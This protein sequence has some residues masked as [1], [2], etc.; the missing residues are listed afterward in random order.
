MPESPHIIQ[1]NID[2]YR[3]ILGRPLVDEQRASIERLLAEAIQHLAL[4]MEPYVR[5]EIAGDEEAPGRRLAT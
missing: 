3:S 5:P 1:M 4:A 2:R